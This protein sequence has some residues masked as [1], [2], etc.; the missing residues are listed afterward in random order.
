MRG[1][2]NKLLLPVVVVSGV[3]NFTHGAIRL[4]QRVVS[5]YYVTVTGLV[6]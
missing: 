2:F 5:M 4:D 3:F 1:L 6:L